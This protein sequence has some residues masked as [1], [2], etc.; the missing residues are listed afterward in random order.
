MTRQPCPRR[1]SRSRPPW[2]RRRGRRRRA[3]VGERTADPVAVLE[4]TGDVHSMKTSIRCGRPCPGASGS[5]RGR[6]GRRCGRAAGS[7]CPPNARCDILPSGVRSKTVPHCSSSRTRSGASCACSSAMR[8]LFRYLPPNIVS[9]KCVCQSSSGA[10]LP[11]A[12][13][14][15]PSAIT[16]CALP[17]SD[18]QTSAVRAPAS[19]AAIAA[20]SP[21]PPAPITRTS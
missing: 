11:N 15:P 10:T 3:A 2:A 14:M 7:V 18:L 19:E 5:A 13:A 20:R 6:C 21:A 9:W 16:V 1:R 8:Q 12:A 17:S 4:Q